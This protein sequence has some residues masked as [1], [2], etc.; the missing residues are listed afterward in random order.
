M[1]GT[2]SKVKP[3][4]GSSTRQPAYKHEGISGSKGRDKR[5]ALNAMLKDVTR[6]KF[7]M[8]MA[9][10]VDRLGASARICTRP[11]LTCSCIS[12]GWTPRGESLG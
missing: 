3:H 11:E 6:R 5:P 2:P 12:K 9:W 8:V 10:S 7:D 4:Q 1:V